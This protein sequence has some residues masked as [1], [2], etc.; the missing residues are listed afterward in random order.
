MKVR[1]R[2]VGANLEYHLETFLNNTEYP[3]FQNLMLNA[4]LETL[5]R[6]L[7]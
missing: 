5:F 7:F 6:H 2:E 3:Q 4:L 1:A